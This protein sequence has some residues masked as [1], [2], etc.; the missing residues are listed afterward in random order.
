MFITIVV[1]A[2]EDA[3]S[4]SLEHTSQVL[5]KLL[6]DLTL[7][8]QSDQV[9][10]L[11][12][13]EVQNVIWIKVQVLHKEVNDLQSSFL[14]QNFSIAVVNLNCFVLK[15][16]GFLVCILIFLE[17]FIIFEVVGFLLLRFVSFFFHCFKSRVRIIKH[18]CFHEWCCPESLIT[19]VFGPLFG[20]LG[21]LIIL[22]DYDN[23]P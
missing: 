15:V 3:L 14:D 18:V 7:V 8:Q 12:L 1:A 20:N 19:T 22:N 6:E 5:C 4:L 9:P 21:F 10:D 2:D 13:G 11:V 16:V 23:L 17:Q